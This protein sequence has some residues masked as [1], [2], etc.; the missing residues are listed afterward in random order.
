MVGD[1]S[2]P[3]VAGSTFVGHRIGRV[4]GRGGMGVVYEAHH[5]TLDRFAAI[6][7]RR[8]DGDPVANHRFLREARAVARV[9][10]MW[11]PCWMPAL[12]MASCFWCWNL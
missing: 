1:Q 11:L 3:L 2:G 7:V 5:L 9:T 6:K 12:P 10:T 8:V 4:L